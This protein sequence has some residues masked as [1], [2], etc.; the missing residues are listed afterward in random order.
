MGSKAFQTSTRRRFEKVE[1]N[2]KT[3]INFFKIDTVHPLSRMP[4]GFD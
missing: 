2:V 1:E 3:A 4:I